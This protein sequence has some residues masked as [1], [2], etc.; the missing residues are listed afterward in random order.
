M[1]FFI[2]T[3]LAAIQSPITSPA[4]MQNFEIVFTDI[5]NLLSNII[6]ETELNDSVKRLGTYDTDLSNEGR[7]NKEQTKFLQDIIRDVNFSKKYTFNL[8]ALAEKFQIFTKINNTIVNEIYHVLGFIKNNLNVIKW[9]T[10]DEQKM[11]MIEISIVLDILNLYRKD[12]LQNIIEQE[13]NVDQVD[14]NI[15]NESRII[16]DGRYNC[17]YVYKKYGIDK[18]LNITRNVINREY[19][20][21]R[22]P[23][24]RNPIKEDI[25][26]KKTVNKQEIEFNIN[27]NISGKKIHFKGGFKENNESAIKDNEDENEDLQIL[28]KQ[29]LIFFLNLD[30]YEDD[31]NTKTS[32]LSCNWLHKLT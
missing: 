15:D 13:K 28:R 18:K 17:S 7:Y 3:L 9:R 20:K 8:K 23:D 19:R 6:T 25:F 4:T 12:I 24:I 31:E 26:K 21:G 14:L 16:I 2:N 10:Q 30:V 27:K 5:F 29:Y 22:L 32:C 1:L 11:F